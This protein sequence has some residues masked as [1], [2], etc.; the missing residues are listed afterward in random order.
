ME[1]VLF[2]I[3]LA[4][5]TAWALFWILRL[6]VRCGMNDALQMNRDWLRSGDP[7]VVR[8]RP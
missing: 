1:A 4:L 5:L 2:F 3:V 8:Q 6:A 7:D